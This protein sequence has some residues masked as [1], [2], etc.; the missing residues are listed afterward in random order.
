MRIT[1]IEAIPVAIPFEHDGPPTG[2]GGTTWHQLAYL[3][4]KVTTED[5]LTGWGEAFGYNIIPATTAA[6]IHNVKPLALGRDARDIAGL[7]ESLKKPLHL[8]GRGGPVQYAL[9]GLD[10]A[11]WD[12]AGKRAGLPLAQ[13]LGGGS[14]T[15]VVAYNSLLR[16]ND[17]AVVARACGISLERG[18]RR[19]KL[20][21]VTVEAVAAARQAIGPDVD[22]MV[23]VNCAWPAS[24]A[25]EM[26]RKLEPYRLKWLEEP[27]WPPEDL[28]GLERIR[29]ATDVPI[30]VG[31]NIANFWQFRP[32]A[33]CGAIDYLQPSVTKVGGVGEFCQVATLAE[34]AGKRLAPHSPYFGPG[35]LATLHL[36]S[37]YPALIGGI[38]CF[39]VRLENSLFG[40]FGVP[41]SDG[42][43]A[44]PTGPGLGCDPDPA[45]VQRY[46]TA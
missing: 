21:E 8:F 4:V 26:A 39:G 31:E 30:A 42:T 12:L 34:A 46:R 19:I 36:A 1:D 37:R 10:I 43:L 9:S 2:F 15:E 35:L 20:H 41:R 18:F 17:P 45:L 14:R 23:D 13:L 3:L 44:V 6:L 33:A 32:A 25:V 22:L 38:E 24:E 29:A 7:M 5:G 27:V 11:L 28:Q 40:E 16:L